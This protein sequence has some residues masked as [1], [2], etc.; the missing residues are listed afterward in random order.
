MKP[1][2]RGHFSPCRTTRRDRAGFTLVELLVVASI[3]ATMFGLVLAG[4]R[5]SESSELRRA[6]QQFASVLLAAQ[7]RGIGNPAGAAVV[8]ETQG[9]SAI[10]VFNAEVPPPIR[11]TVTG[12]PP[13]DPA[14]STTGVTINAGGADLSRGFR[15][16]FFGAAPLSPPSPW[17][18]LQPPGTVRMRSEDDQTPFNTMWPSTT[19]GQCEAR[20][21]CYPA[22]GD[23]ALPF[24]KSVAVELRYSGTGDDPTKPWGGLAN[25]GDVGLSFDSVGAVDVLAR[26]LGTTGATSRQPVEPVFFLLATRKDITSD[27]ALGSERSLW[28]VV[29]PL[30]GRVTVSAN[31]PQQNRDATAL[32]AAR[33]LARATAAIGK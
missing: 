1:W 25:K 16:Q 4:S 32:R 26:G 6:A 7:S 20:I 12:L 9:T 11:V 8:L 28:V 2:H 18:G 10:M 15:I 5:P 3:I 23:L 31:V 30:T 13:A 27:T 33:A 24:S 29:Q 14:V 19:A 22:K 17:F 21:A